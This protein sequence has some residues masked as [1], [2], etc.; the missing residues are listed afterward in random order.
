MCRGRVSVN[1]CS[2]SGTGGAACRV[3]GIHFKIVKSDKDR[4]TLKF[5]TPRA[6]GFPCIREGDYIA[7][8]DPETLLEVG[9]TKVVSAQLR[10]DLYYDIITAGCEAPMGTKCVVENISACPDFE[11]KGNSL[12]R[13][14]GNGVS[15]M[16]RGKIR[17]EDNKFLNTGA[18][19]IF[20]GDDASGGFESG[21]VTN[22][23]I[24]NN[25]FMNCDES[26]ITVKPE[27]MK[28]AGPVHKN[29]LIENNLFVINNTHALCAFFSDGVYMQGNTYAGEPKYNDWV[30]LKKVTDFSTDEPK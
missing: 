9:R 27:P 21:Y 15:V 25:A 3:H 4:L 7:Y 18:S 22:V 16:S 17:I 26:A 6:Y 8:I 20:I 11:F 24:K 2:F 28:Y 19:A 1:G 30:I 14:L 12:N 23:K 5:P 29:I 13:I 10:D